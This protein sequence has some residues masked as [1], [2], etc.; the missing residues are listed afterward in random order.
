MLKFVWFGMLCAYVCL[1]MGSDWFVIEKCLGSCG[2]AMRQ[3][4][5]K[6]L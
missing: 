4:A 2:G 1:M 3:V 6:G 5:V